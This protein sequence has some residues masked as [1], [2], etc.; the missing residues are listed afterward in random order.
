MTTLT[1]EQLKEANQ[2][3]DILRWALEDVSNFSVENDDIFNG[4]TQR[5]E[6]E[7][8]NCQKQL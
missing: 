1:E 6:E 7:I 3:L 4:I 2:L 8:K 5:I